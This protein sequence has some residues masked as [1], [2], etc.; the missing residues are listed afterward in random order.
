[1]KTP[2]AKILAVLIPATRYIFLSGVI[3]SVGSVHAQT[4]ESVEPIGDTSKIT[5]YVVEQ[6]T[7]FGIANVVVTLTGLDARRRE[8]AITD[9]DGYYEIPELSSGKYR[10]GYQSIP[11]YVI[12]SKADL[13]QEIYLSNGEDHG[14]VIFQI[15]AG[16]SVS[17]VARNIDG[18]PVDGAE[19]R[20]SDRSKKG[21]AISDASGR[22]K[23]SG[24][25]KGKHFVSISSI[26]YSNS[27]LWAVAGANDLEFVLEQQRRVSGR[28]VDSMSGESFERF[29]VALISTDPQFGI[30]ALTELFADYEEG[31]FVRYAPPVGELNLYVRVPGHG[32]VVFQVHQGGAG[33]MEIETVV[34]VPKGASVS[35][36]VRD[37]QGSP[38]PDAELHVVPPTMGDFANSMLAR[39]N[40]KGY[41]E[42][43]DI[44]PE[45]IDL[46]VHAEG[47]PELKLHF[48]PRRGSPNEYDIVLDESAILEGYLTLNGL[49]IADTRLRIFGNIEDMVSGKRIRAHYDESITTEQDGFF[50]F[51]GIAPGEFGASF[52]L[53]DRDGQFTRSIRLQIPSSGVVLQDVTLNSD[54]AKL[55]VRVHWAPA[56]DMAYHG[57]YIQYQDGVF[58]D[59]RRSTGRNDDVYH[60]PDLP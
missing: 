30:L 53:Q 2:W 43:L 52:R 28:V 36:H 31:V 33:Q 12:D 13:N 3:L 29:S 24:L 11:G 10:V 49:P 7:G 18:K 47:H 57:I 35:G 14:D 59:S 51:T 58:Y 50:R 17:G 32:A 40:A 1:M 34:E 23:I 16:M 8:I 38:I 4:T 46:W 25:A 27:N 37:A 22:F 21:I 44:A 39:T 56:D 20:M 55:E 42:I 48:E 60:F 54:D 41:F 6:E 15:F 26:G 9:T 45:P 5:G 19:I